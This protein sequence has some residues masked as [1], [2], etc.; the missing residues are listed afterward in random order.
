M[1]VGVA[2]SCACGASWK[3]D[4]SRVGKLVQ[5]PKCAD[6]VPVPRVDTEAV[7]VTDAPAFFAPPKPAPEGKRCPSCGRGYEYDPR[8][9]PHC[10]FRLSGRAD[11]GVLPGPSPA[12]ESAPEVVRGA[13]A[14]E[15]WVVLCFL[16]IGIL[17]NLISLSLCGIA[18]GAVMFYGVLKRENWAWWMVVVL[19][20][21]AGILLAVVAALPD[22]VPSSVINPAFLWVEVALRALI[23]TL[24]IVCRARGAYFGA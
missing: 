5:C 22:V 23:V 9:C 13:P 17:V 15:I 10:G 19:S 20:T 3:V 21:L 7:V 8:V 14:W 11:T 2:L 18:V 6:L 16:G 12:V 1:I 4:E 24:M